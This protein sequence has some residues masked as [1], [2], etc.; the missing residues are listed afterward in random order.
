MYIR[1]DISEWGAYL[2]I[3]WNHQ[4]DK[5]WASNLVQTRTKL[6]FYIRKWGFSQKMGIQP[7]AMGVWRSRHEDM[8][9]KDWRLQDLPNGLILPIQDH[10]SYEYIPSGR[11]IFLQIHRF[12]WDFTLL[13]PTSVSKRWWRILRT[14]VAWA[15]NV[16]RF[17]AG[18]R[19]MLYRIVS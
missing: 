5:H 16:P 19:S 7:E 12:C 3:L 9:G 14:L 6:W 18:F 15:S 13:R 10:E 17:V 8:W 4:S 1:G 11:R 2:W